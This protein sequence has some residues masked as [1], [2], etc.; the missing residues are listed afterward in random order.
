MPRRIAFALFRPAW[1]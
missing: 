1:I